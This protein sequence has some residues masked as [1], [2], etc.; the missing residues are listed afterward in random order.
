MNKTDTEE[1][2][3]SVIIPTYNR[4]KLLIRAIQSVIDQTVSP[5]ELI[6]VDD[7]SEF[8]VEK[9]LDKKI[10]CS[11]KLKIIIN[12]SNFGGAKSR[13]IGVKNASGKYVAFLDSDDYWHEKKIELIKKKLK[14]KDIDLIYSDQ[15]IVK[16]NGK[17]KESNKVLIDNNLWENLLNGWT[18][19]NTSTLVFARDK[20]L[21]IGGFNSNL[22]SCQ[23]HDLWMKV[24]QNNLDLEFIEKRLSYFTRDADNRISFNIEKRISGAISFLENWRKEIIETRNKKFYKKF[25]NK[26]IFK[27][28]F[29]IFIKQIKNFNLFKA[30]K[31]YLK[32]FKFDL[33]F[34]KQMLKNFF[35][36]D[37]D[38][39]KDRLY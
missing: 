4:K 36:L 23:D 37:F 11:F 21:E 39:F 8:D 35:D 25:K 27:V 33:F 29:P 31:L 19:P 14:I 38:F 24:A 20:L 22:K 6:I 9:Y 10:N 32:Y 1:P 7:K 12:P 3:I 18:A 17:L 2:T 16:E 13:N 30:I 5:E 15:W 34:Y 26:Y 28:L